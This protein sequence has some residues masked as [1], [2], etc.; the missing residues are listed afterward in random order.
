[1][2]VKLPAANS[3][4]LMVEDSAAAAPL[5]QMSDSGDQRKFGSTGT[6]FS[7]CEKDGSGLDRRPVVMPD[8][9][10]S[11]CLVT[12]AASSGDDLIDVAGGTASVG[13][14]TFSV[15]PQTDFSITRPSAS[16]KRISSVVINS[17]GTASVIAGT[18]AA[19]YSG[20]RGAAGGAPYIPL[21][22]IELATVRLDSETAAPLASDE[23]FFAPEFTHTPS[24]KLLPYSA[25]LEFSAP[26]PLIHT[27]DAAKNVWLT[28][29]EPSLS[30]LDVASLRPPALS[31]EI[32]TATGK[33]AR[34]KYKP[35]SIV[36]ALSGDQSVLA[37]RID[38]TVR[39]F[40][41]MPDS[42][43]TRKELFY[44]AVEI[45][46]DYS[47]GGLMAGAATLLPVE[48]LSIET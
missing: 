13:G 21:G 5:E 35:G 3:L 39:L 41:F 45:V 18:E 43:Q 15:S 23:V 7:L 47:P 22:Q 27:G 29:F 19:D 17:S 24:Y 36:I 33:A 40:E 28:W 25:S 16:M 2:S 42:T 6:R 11:G 30:Q 34:G 8:G 31:F 44:A 26:L 4:Q 37:R 10:Q 38:G 1:M 48:E 9:V 12:P 32:D 14:S 46:A 20:Q